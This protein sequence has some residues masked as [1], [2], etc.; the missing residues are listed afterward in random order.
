MVLSGYFDCLFVILIT[1]T[2]FSAFVVLK[3]FLTCYF[4]PTKVWYHTQSGHRAHIKQS[5]LQSQF[6]KSHNFPKPFINLFFPN[7]PLHHHADIS[8]ISLNPPCSP[9]CA[10]CIPRRRAREIPL[11]GDS[12]FPEILVFPRWVENWSW[13]PPYCLF[14]PQYIVTGLKNPITNF[15]GLM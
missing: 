3:P 10:G 12:S 2:K 6:Q 13:T 8:D 5:S 4:P 7:Q 1:K 11:L 9:C 15:I 14:Y